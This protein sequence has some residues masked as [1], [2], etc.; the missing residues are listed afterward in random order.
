MFM[1]SCPAEG[2][3][4]DKVA[5]FVS[6]GSEGSLGGLRTDGLDFL[7]DLV[8]DEIARQEPDSRVIRLDRD[9]LSDNGI[10]FGR[11][12]TA[13]FQRRTSEGGRVVWLVV[14]DLPINDWQKSLEALNGKDTQVFFFTTACRQVPCCFKLINN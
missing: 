3:P 4:R 13:E 11:D 14:Q 1:T 5:G 9:Y 6:D 10:D 8:A 7:V 12:L 2:D